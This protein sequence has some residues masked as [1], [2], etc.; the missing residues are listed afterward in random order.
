[1]EKD[2][3]DCEGFTLIELIVVICIIGV[4]SGII[5]FSVTQYISRGKDSN[6]VGQLATLIPSGEV[7]YNIGN[8]YK[9]FCTSTV[10][11]NAFSQMPSG[12]DPL[13]RVDTYNNSYQSWVACA[14]SFSN[15]SSVYCVDSRGV[16]KEVQSGDCSVITGASGSCASTYAC[17][18]P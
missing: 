12:A 2:Y 16:K 9:D 5:L 15:P 11:S 10:V 4:L 13:C 7:Y 6:T 3:K 18:C 1:M 14:K 8:T 17:Q